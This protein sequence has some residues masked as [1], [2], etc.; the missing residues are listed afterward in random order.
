M[1]HPRKSRHLNVVEEETNC[2]RTPGAMA[3]SP[4]ARELLKVAADWGKTPTQFRDER[5][6]RLDA[7]PP[8]TANIGVEK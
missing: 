2:T 4:V 7:H 8:Q 3:D 1:K 5:F 6:D